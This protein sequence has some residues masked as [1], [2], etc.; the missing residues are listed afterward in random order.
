[1]TGALILTYHAVE[2]GPAPLCV[3]PDL[4]REHLDVLAEAG[5]VHHTLS[6]LAAAFEHDTVPERAVAVTFDDGFRS[7][8]E[9]AVPQL[10]DAGAS[11]T[12]FAVAGALGGYNDWPSQPGSAPVRPLMDAGQLR[13]LA[14][15]GIE[16]GSHGFEHAPLV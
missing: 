8:F 7:V 14:D 16:I 3:H 9:H 12:V 15:A 10:A 5:A 1:M 13:E 11:A 4:F 6:E 2:P